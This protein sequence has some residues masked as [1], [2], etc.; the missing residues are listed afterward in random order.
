MGDLDAGLKTVAD[1]PAYL[2]IVELLTAKPPL[3]NARRPVVH[4]LKV[5]PPERILGLLRLPG[6][7]DEDKVTVLLR[8]VHARGEL[9]VG[10]EMMWEEFADGRGASASR[11]RALRA[12]PQPAAAE[13]F[14]R[15][16]QSAPKSAVPPIASNLVRMFR[17]QKVKIGPLSAAMAALDEDAVLASCFE[18][19][20]RSC[21]RP[22]RR[23]R[24]G[25]GPAA[26]RPPPHAPQASRR[27]RRAA[28]ADPRRAAPPGQRP[29]SSRATAWDTCRRQIQEVSRLQKPDAS[30]APPIRVKLLDSACRDLAKAADPAMAGDILDGEYTWTQKR[31][32]LL[33]IAQEQLGGLSLLPPG[34]WEHEELLKR[35]GV[36][37]QQHHWPMEPLKRRRSR[38]RG[39]AR[40]GWWARQRN[41]WPQ[42][43]GGRSSWSSV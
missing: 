23:A 22:T 14:V 5:A 35:I 11:G 9:P 25:D 38:P 12:D 4:L 20:A 6:V 10:C 37:F 34:P 42:R 26:F 43:R 39:K 28:P 15:L 31:D 33:R 1:G 36:Q 13:G 27:V 29:V 30:I 8:Q 17:Q 40:G 2:T 3:R 21:L 7:P 41:Q 18:A 19:R 24:A 32:T 16:F